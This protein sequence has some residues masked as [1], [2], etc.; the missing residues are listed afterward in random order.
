M[1]YIGTNF[2]IFQCIWKHILTKWRFIT[3]ANGLA[4]EEITVLTIRGDTSSNPSDLFPLNAD[5]ISTISCGITSCM[6]IQ[7]P[8]WVNSELKNSRWF[9]STDGIF[10]AR[11]LPMPT[12]KIIKFIANFYRIFYYT[13]NNFYF[14]NTITFFRFWD[15]IILIILQVLAMSPFGIYNS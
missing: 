10:F 1:Y 2:G 9:R 5:T 13:I 4:I 11:W 6:K 14:S 7:L 8:V 15:K 3:A 12:K